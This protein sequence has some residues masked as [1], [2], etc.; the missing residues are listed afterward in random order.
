MGNFYIITSSSCGPCHIFKSTHMLEKL[1]KFLFDNIQNINVYWYDRD[2]NGKF[3][4]KEMISENNS[5]DTNVRQDIINNVSIF[6]QLMYQRMADGKIFEDVFAANNESDWQRLL[7]FVGDNPDIYPAFSDGFM[8]SDNNDF[9]QRNYLQQN[10]RQ[11]QSPRSSP[12]RSSPSRRS[13][14][15]RQ[16]PRRSSPRRQNRNV[17]WTQM[18]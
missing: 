10:K 13:S 6:P 14:P 1:V 3:N 7:E 11:Q 16:S 15:R 18:R 4:A 2:L 5:E 12:R 8:D 17:R 9:K